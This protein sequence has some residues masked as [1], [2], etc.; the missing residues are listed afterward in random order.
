MRLIIPLALLALTGCNLTGLQV[1]GA[2]AEGIQGPNNRSLE[3]CKQRGYN[4]YSQEVNRQ[5]VV[6]VKWV[7]YGKARQ[8]Q[9]LS[10]LEC[11]N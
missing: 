10:E 3:A 1:A 6:G 5:L 7:D 11:L 4:A 8:A 9:R 2:I